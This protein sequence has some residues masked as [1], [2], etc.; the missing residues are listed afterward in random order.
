LYSSDSSSILQADALY[1]KNTKLS[2]WVT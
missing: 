2:T 1:I